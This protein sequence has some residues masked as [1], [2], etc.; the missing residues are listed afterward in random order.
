M[1]PSLTDHLARRL[2]FEH[3]LR[4]LETLVL[5]LHYLLPWL[6]WMESHHPV[7]F[8]RLP[9]S[10]EFSPHRWE[11]LC[12]PSPTGIITKNP[13]RDFC[14]LGFLPQW[15]PC[16]FSPEGYI[17]RLILHGHRDGRIRL[18]GAATFGATITSNFRFIM[19]AFPSPTPIIMGTY[20][21]YTTLVASI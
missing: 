21:Y 15:F 6:R 12:H 9:N 20:C 2:R 13:R 5:P 1:T 3:R 16:A 8:M 14:L 7:K 10:L 19:W 18:A 17:Q 4:V 11:W